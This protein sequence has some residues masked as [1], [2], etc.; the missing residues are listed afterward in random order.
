MNSTAEIDRLMSLAYELSEADRKSDAEGAFLAASKLAPSW[1]VPW[2]ELGLLC[3]YQGRWPESLEY[4]QRSAELDPSDQAAWWNLGIAATAVGH[5]PA[6]RRAWK[7]CG[8][9]LP[10]GD[11]APFVDF[12]LVP[13]RLEPDA[14]GEVVWAHRIDPA[15]ARIENVP[16]PTTPFRWR[17]LVLHDGAH[18]GYRV[19]NGREVPVFNVLERLEQSGF[20]TF[21]LE[22]GSS[23]TSSVERLRSIAEELGGAAED[24]G[25]TTNIL[26]RNCSLG[27]PHAHADEPATPAHPHC[28]VAARDLDHAEQIIE[29]WLANTPGA[30]LVR[31]SS[32]EG[33]V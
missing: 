27:V 6:A 17:D 19:L 7:A 22:L 8:I 16:L 5:W 20:G 21:V 10:E 28:G 3:K 2:Y 26:C 15:R 14:A 1:A 32:I 29:R 25:T 24:W 12:G 31:W 11:D 30:D 4:N 9:T 33:A 18:E 13:V 23:D